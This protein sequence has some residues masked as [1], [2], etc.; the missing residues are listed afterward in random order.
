MLQE[1]HLSTYFRNSNVKLK[2]TQ[3][4]L[5]KRFSFRTILP[6]LG[7]FAVLSMANSCQEPLPEE[8]GMTLSA[9]EVQVSAEGGLMELPYDLTGFDGVP[10]I[11]AVYDADWIDGFDFSKEGLIRF[12]VLPTD[13][14]EQRSASVRIV[15]PGFGVESSFNVIQ[16][17][18]EI[19]DLAI[20]T[21]GLV[22]NRI[23]YNVTPFDKDMTYIVLGCEKSRV[24]D[25]TTDEQWYEAD[26]E[27]FELLMQYYG[28]P[29]KEVLALLIRTGNMRD[30]AFYNLTPDLD[31]C[32]YAYG[33]TPEGEPTTPIVKEYYKTPELVMSE[34]SFDFNY[35]IY[36]GKVSVEVI[37]DN[38]EQFYLFNIVKKTAY[39]GDDELKDYLQAY[40]DDMTLK[41]ESN[42]W[43]SQ[44]AAVDTLT[45][46]GTINKQ[47][48]LD[49]ETEYVAYA[50]NV[51]R[52]GLINSDIVKSEFATQPVQPS[53]NVISIEITDIKSNNITV[54]MDA[55]NEDPYGYAAVPVSEVEGFS[56]DEILA[57]L[58]DPDYVRLYLR[59][60]SGDKTYTIYS[61]KPD[62]EY[63]FCAFGFEHNVVTTPLFKEAFTTKAE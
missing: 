39:S 11:K 4:Q 5:M 24:A 9:E 56:D 50:V 48:S 59:L 53:E 58:T 20:T 57:K 28:L 36:G 32:I 51:S 37:P 8:P 40:L 2:N 44:E 63:V 27:Y 34:N 22:E 19:P 21:Y 31:Y 49:P 47:Y 6:L 54:V 35:D 13:S 60:A 16:Y 3:L 33:M 38:A 17:E 41:W 1:I 25:F 23:Y 43:I 52:Y 55:T 7:I 62:T 61:L 30:E 42:T 29:F 46:S 12:N 45:Y 18:G 26:R 14:R 15:V 10:E